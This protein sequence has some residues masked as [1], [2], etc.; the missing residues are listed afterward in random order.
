MARK[1]HE[2]V[3]EELQSLGYKYVDGEYKN[4]D[5]PLEVVC[6][7]NHETITTLKKLRRDPTCPICEMYSQIHLEEASVD[8]PPPTKKGRRIL[9]LDNATKVVGYAIFEDGELISS[10]VKEV[11]E[12]S[13][14]TKR[15]ASVKHWMVAIIKHWKI[16]VLG[17]EDVYYSGNPQT[18]I[19]LSKLLGVL[20]NAGAELDLEVHTVLPGT[21]RRYCNIKGR[22]RSVQKENAQR[23]VQKTHG[24]IASQDKADA[25]C[26]GSYVLSKENR[27]GE[28]I[29]WG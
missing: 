10:G 9:A 15:I 26:L 5:S 28:I 17:L 11:P 18:C 7:K 8:V 25:I 1:T 16:D 13:N 23:Y 6:N 3:V 22:K 14:S 4:L 27:F 2:E 21:W 20:E 19:L 29:K 12:S 24:V